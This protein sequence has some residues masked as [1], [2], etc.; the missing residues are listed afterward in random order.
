MI[1]SYADEETKPLCIC[2]LIYITESWDGWGGQGPLTA[3]AL[4]PA[5]AEIPRAGGPGPH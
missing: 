2:S 5:Q 4:T 3:S 1:S